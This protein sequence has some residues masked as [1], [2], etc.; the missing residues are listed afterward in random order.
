VLVVARSGKTH[1]EE[2]QQM[3]IQLRVKYAIVGQERVNTSLRMEVPGH[4]YCLGIDNITYFE[5]MVNNRVID[6]REAILISI[7]TL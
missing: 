4:I 7:Y 2:E 1:P 6:L 3:L 5:L